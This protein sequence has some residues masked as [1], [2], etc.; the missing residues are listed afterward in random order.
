[1]TASAGISLERPQDPASTTRRRWWALLVIAI[2]QL[3]I[4]LDATI[5]NI[6][7]PTIATQLHVSDVDRQW[8]VTA[9]TLA[10]AGFLLLGGRVGD[11]I[12]RKPAFLIALGGFAL[13]SVLGGLSTSLPML[14]AGRAIQGVFGALLF[15]TGLSLLSTTFTDTA[16][17]AKAF[18]V[19]GAVAGGGSAIGLTLGGVL[20]EYLS[21]GWVFFV[22]VPLAILTAMGAVAWVDD[23]QPPSRTRL[24][25][26]GALLVGAG[27]TAAVY[28][29][30]EAGD[31]G[32]FAPATFI[33]LTA[34]V[35]LLALFG[36][37]EARVAHPLL[38]LR[39]ITDR[40]R[41]SAFIT[42][43]LAMVALF[44]MIFFLSF[45]VQGVQAYT[46]VVAGIAF[47]PMT[48][49]VLVTSIVSSRIA[50][51]KLTSRFLTLGLL[52]AA[53]G[54][55]WLSQLR[56][57]SGYALHILPALVITGLGLGLIFP[58]AANVAT[59]GVPPRDAGVASATL[60][61]SQQIGASLGTASLNTLAAAHTAA[62]LATVPRPSSQDHL[63]ATAE[64]YA[65]ACAWGAGTLT[66]ASLLLMFASRA[67][68]VPTP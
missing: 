18:A 61:A 7:L 10:F 21:W 15:P 35:A 56:I 5:V 16:E 31:R 20:V 36:V 39:L 53:A 68:R 48:A 12:G 2:A 67:R 22:N 17:R 34:G 1:M 66:V 54:L 43:M 59:A 30:G 3:M 40:V 49:G 27:L 42:Q 52:L 29:F 26:V 57:D 64:G 55:A 44:G 23:K 6:A 8:V 47:L 13:A 58:N 45:F 14:L 51:P 9:Y 25:V 38:P 62:I 28:G 32:W 24:D 60:N 37:V 50:T 4:V 65:H 41:C 33:P 19:F 11:Y 63:V 46:P